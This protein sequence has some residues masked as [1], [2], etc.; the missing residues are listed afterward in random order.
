MGFVPREFLKGAE[1]VDRR[2]EL[3]EGEGLDGQGG[4]GGGREGVA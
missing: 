3:A 4:E 2:V 1:E